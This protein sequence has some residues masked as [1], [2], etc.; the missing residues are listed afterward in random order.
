[1]EFQGSG[2]EQGAL[3]AAGWP[4]NVEPLGVFGPVMMFLIGLLALSVSVSLSLYLSN[5]G[6]ILSISRDT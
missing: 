4:V 5:F 6:M 2:G 3:Q 1:M